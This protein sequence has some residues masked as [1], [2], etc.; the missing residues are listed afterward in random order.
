M[1]LLYILVNGYL[2]KQG[3]DNILQKCLTQDKVQNNAQMTT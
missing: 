1:A 3:I 2:Y